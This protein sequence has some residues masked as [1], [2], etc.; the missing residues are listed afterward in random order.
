MPDSGEEDN[1]NLVETAIRLVR[2]EQ[3]IAVRDRVFEVATRGF[4]SVLSHTISID[5]GPNTI[6]NQDMIE[7]PE[8]EIKIVEKGEGGEP[9]LEIAVDGE[10]VIKLNL[11]VFNEEG[12]REILDE[13]IPTDLDQGAFSNTNKSKNLRS[14]L[15]VSLLSPTEATRCHPSS[16]VLQGRAHPRGTERLRPERD[17][18]W[19]A[20]EPG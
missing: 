18:G 9:F 7:H 15:I 1:A 6:Y 11:E 14:F 12:K 5:V 8:Q 10:I 2:S 19:H 3:V 4:M 13:L 16:M 17:G 20:A